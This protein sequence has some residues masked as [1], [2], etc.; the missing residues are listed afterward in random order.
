MPRQSL[1]RQLNYHTMPDKPSLTAPQAA[2]SFYQPG[3]H[4]PQQSVGYLMRKVLGSIL[5]QADTRLAMH[6]VTYVQYLPLYKLLHCDHA[7]ATVATLARELEVDAG[8]M[9]RALDRLQAKGLVERE[10]STAD[11]RVVHLT[12]T[13]AGRTVAEQVPGVLADVLNGHLRGFSKPEWQ[14]LLQ[15]LQRML[16]NGDAL[17]PGAA[18]Q[19]APAAAPVPATHG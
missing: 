13:P 14:Q 10:R 9:T 2:P 3:Q 19:A 17:R 15:L 11:R 1:S 18:T 8:A 5:S 4:S 16:A 12:L 7:D 6:D